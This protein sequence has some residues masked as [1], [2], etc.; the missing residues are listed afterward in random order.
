MQNEQLPSGTNPVEQTAADTTKTINLEA[1]IAKSKAEIEKADGPPKRGRGRPRKIKPEASSSGVRH[2][3]DAPGAAPQSVEA[4]QLNLTPILQQALKLPFD[5]AAAKFKCA[6]I[7]L[8][9]EEAAAPA[10][11]A[12]Q[13]L[14][15][16]MPDV[17]NQDP[18]V[19]LVWSFAFSIGML[20]YSKF[21]AYQV[22]AKIELEAQAKRVAENN[23]E[24][25]ESQPDADPFR[26][27][28]Q[29]HVSNY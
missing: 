11:I 27:Q 14:N 18:K 16:Y 10:Q 22:S 13:L 19:V 2:P 24:K 20:S 4:P 23:N 9:D 6:D 8:T 26:R 12:E 5:I 29:F 15:A 21:Q 7:C 1:A 17:I 28:S 25:K 3:S